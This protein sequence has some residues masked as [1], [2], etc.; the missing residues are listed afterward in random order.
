MDLVVRRG[1]T[2]ERQRKGRIVVDPLCTE[3][4]SRK[5]PACNPIVPPPR[6]F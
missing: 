4:I 2:H 5:D 6:P 1:I 3:S